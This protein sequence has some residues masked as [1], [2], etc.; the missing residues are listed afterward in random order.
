MT[1]A[2]TSYMTA[3]NIAYERKDSRKFVKKRLVA[4]VMVGCIGLAFLLVAGLLVFGP[5]IEKYLGRAVGMPSTFGW[6]W[7]SAA[8]ADPDRRPAR[9]LRDAALARPRRQAAQLEVHHARQRRHR[10]H[11]ARGLG[12]VRL[13]HEQLRLVQ[14][15]VGLARRR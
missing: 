1:G 2:M 13:L 14:Q 3:L 5:P 12:R 11:L 6:L 8:V 7:W 15:D 4:L 9:R 10:R